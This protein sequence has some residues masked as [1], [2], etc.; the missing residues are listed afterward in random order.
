VAVGEMDLN[1]AISSTM[2]KPA[3]SLNKMT[4]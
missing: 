1:Q 2:N 3:Y 4:A